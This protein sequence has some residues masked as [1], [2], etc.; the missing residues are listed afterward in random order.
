MQYQHRSDAD[1]VEAAV[2]ALAPDVPSSSPSSVPRRRI[3]RALSGVVV[4]AAVLL[5]LSS[6]GGEDD[7]GDE[8]DDD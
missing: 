8:E 2:T 3:L 1:D 7:E 4:G 5:G 6:C